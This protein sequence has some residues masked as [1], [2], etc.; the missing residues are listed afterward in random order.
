MYLVTC[1]PSFRPDRQATATG[2]G[3][4]HIKIHAA[5]Q[6]DAGYYWYPEINEGS[7]TLLAASSGRP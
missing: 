6:S 2:V 1:N 5:V 3:L 4:V 7:L